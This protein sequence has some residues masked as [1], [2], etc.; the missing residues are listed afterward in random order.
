MNTKENLL[1]TDVKNRLSK[2]LVLIAMLLSVGV[3][4]QY[5]INGTGSA[6]TYTQN[7]DT[8]RGTSATLPT[9]WTNSTNSYNTSYP[10]ITSGA[11]SP[12][13]AQ[14]SGNNCYAGRANSSSTDY[15]ILQ[16][17]ATSG[18]TYLNFSAA[19]NTG[20]I[21]TG[22]T[23][24]WNVEQYNQAARATT[25][26]F[27]YRIG[28]GS[29]T[30]TDISGTTLYTA[31]T[32]SS[33]AFSVIQT[34][35]SI[36]ITGVSIPN[37]TSID[38]RFAIANGATSGSNAHIGIDDFTMYATATATCA[39]PT[40]SATTSAA[41]IT[42]STVNLTGDI[43]N[44]G[45]AALTTRAFEYST[46]SAL[47]SSSTRT[48]ASTST[49]TYTLGLTSLTPNTR[50]Y[51]RA[52]AINGCSTPQTGYSHT[53][54]YPSFTT[55]SNAPTTTAATVLTTTGFQANWTAPTGGGSESFTYEIQI[56]NNNDLSSPEVNQT[57][58]STLNYSAGPLSS[59]TIY[60]YRVR[61]LNAGGNSAW[62]NITSVTT[63][64]PAVP[65]VSPA[66]FNGTVGS[67]FSETVIAT[68]SPT[69][70]TYTGTL[71]VGLSLNA[72]NG[73][74]TG[75]PTTATISA[76]S[77]SVTAT[78]GVGPSAPATISFN[79]AKGNQTITG[80]PATQSKVYG[81]V[82]YSLSATASS[83][84]AVSY[85]SSDP[86]VAT[87]TGNTV[88]IKK[89]GTTTITASQAGDSNWN[90]ASNVTQTLSVTAKALTISG[91]SGVDK[92]YDRTTTA[93]L[94]G[95]PALVTIVSGDDVS[96][97]GTPVANFAD[98]NV[99]TKSLTVTGYT[100]SGT[101]AGNYT[102]SQ[103]TGL[104]ANITAKALTI[105]GAVVNNKT[106]DGL[107]SATIT[108]TLSGVISPDVVTLSG[109]GT[110]ASVNAANGITV[111][112]TSTIGGANAGNYTLT[113]PTGLTANITKAN[114]VITPS[115]IGVSV[116]G[117]YVLPN[118]AFT[119]NSDG[120]ITYSMTSGGFATLSGTT[121]TGVAVGSETLT[122][123]QAAS[124]NYNAATSVTVPVSVS[125][126]TYVDG[127]WK[128][129]STGNW[130]STA[131]GSTVTWARRVSGS[132]VAQT[133]PAQA[134]TSGSANKIYIY[135]DVTLAGNNTA[136]DIVI[137]I[138]PT[139][140]TRIGVLHANI[141]CTFGKLVV[142]DG[143]TFSKEAN[144]VSIDSEANGG[145]LEIKDGGT[146]LYKHT[147]A[148]S[149]AIWAAK[150][151]F[152]ANSIFKVVTVNSSAMLVIPNTTDVSTYTDP[153]TGTTACFGNVIIDCATGKMNLVPSGFNLPLTHKD[154]IFRNNSD[155]TPLSTG[156]ITTTVGGNLVVE[157]TY[158]ETINF[159]ST[160]STINITVKGNFIHNGT[161]AFR[162]TTVLGAN[163]I[164][165]IEGNLLLN[166]GGSFIM[167]GGSGS[168]TGTSTVNLKGNLTISS[169]SIINSTATGANNFNFNGIG[170][171]LTSA[172]LQAIDIAS[173]GST[174]NN[175]INF[176][177]NSGAYAK[178]INQNLALGTNSSLNVL[179][180]GSLDFGLSGA[181]AL[182]VTGPTFVANSGSILKITS[183]DGVNKTGVSAGNVQTTS[184]T[185]NNLGTYHFIGSL[186]PQSTGNAIENTGTNAFALNL[187][188]NKDN[189][190]DIV[191]LN[192]NTKTTGELNIIKGTFVETEANKIAGTTGKLTMAADGIY[193]TAVTSANTPQLSGTYSLAS[194]STIELNANANQNFNASNTITYRNLIFSNGGTKTI[195][196]TNE[197][198]LGTVTIKDNTTVDASTNTFGG[199]GTNLTM[200]DTSK[201]ILGS[202][203]DP[204]P[205][206]D[207]VY[208]L[209]SS[210]TIEFTGNSSTQ[211]RVQ[212]TATSPIPYAK[213]IVSGTNV[214]AGT[215]TST[216]LTF[217]TSGVF[218]VT[219][220][221]VYKV[222]NPA[223]FSGGTVTAVKNTNNP[224]INLE[225]G[226]TVE[227]NGT[228]DQTITV[229]TLAV[230]ATGNYQN[231]SISGSGTKSPVG[232][233]TVNNLTSVSGGI[234]KILE[235][236]ENDPANVLYAHK[237]V[238]NTT[239]SVIFEN[240]AQL[241][242][243]SDA[244]NSGNIESQRVASNINNLTA[245]M[246]YIYWSS[247]VSGQDLKS[248]SP[249]TPINRIYQ[250]NEATDFFA[251]I[252]FTTEPNFV[253]G[254][255]YAFRAE[256]TVVNGSSKVYKFVGTPNNGTVDFGINRSANSGT[257][258]HGYNLVG[259]PYPSN[260]KFS[261][262]YL[263]NSSLIWN[264]AYFWT[265]NNFTAQ[266]A[267]SN[268]TPNNYAIFNGTGGN[269]AT[270]SAVGTGVTATPNGIVK[271]GQ[272]FIV[273]KKVLG[274]GTLE[275]KN[276]YS[277]SNVLRVTDTGAFFEKNNSK[278]RFWLEM[279]APNN[280]VNTILVGYI[281]GAT[282]DFEIDYDGELF[283]VGSDSFYSVLGAKKLAIQGKSDNF[284][285][286][287]IVPLGTVYSATGTYSIKLKDPEGIFGDGQNVYLR[288]KLL[289]KYINL[290]SVE[291]YSFTGTKGTN[292]TRF[293]IVYKEDAVLGTGND[294]K[295]D[296]VVYRDGDSFVVRS[297]KTLG[298]IEI[299]DS[300]GRLVRQLSSKD[301]MVRLDV[302]DLPGAIYIIKAD[303]SGDIK[304][305]KIIK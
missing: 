56:D 19:N 92:I 175:N 165:T 94:S 289:N 119:T 135:T 294:S 288:D 241:L 136:K 239:G 182:N 58:I 99:G 68:N 284:N 177:V 39:A 157:N 124:T 110:F 305:K 7:F 207:G 261:E 48:E 111:T 273:Q 25:V 236:A 151:M 188:I 282:N 18:Q 265:N 275:F 40:V 90:A 129:T 225:T 229:G 191:N 266:Q 17:Q 302:S 227:Y 167:N 181:T 35:R 155:T 253:A 120:A 246:D 298:D 293:E 123:N 37:G 121:I 301:K 283:V 251:G 300:G 122:V 137:G 180:G 171:G 10:V 162:P 254:K 69:N 244:A 233:L 29:Y 156:N 195:G 57:G 276:S 187:I 287:D 47:A 134:P 27:D 231:L 64:T 16:K 238:Q 208:N 220:T 296:F 93:S 44:Q 237:G 67:V 278:D 107:N 222:P 281:P 224:T 52:Y 240:N 150:E 189:A 38:F 247:P 145:I 76:I 168:L 88:S 223:G 290:N 184:R 192:T 87:V 146:F 234:L 132:W 235:T 159:A 84:L 228:A 243:D 53:S 59:G 186:T 36:T 51:Y 174:R 205:R 250:Y 133:L 101:K 269:G 23:V 213:V 15:A 179:S 34:A 263:G 114:A 21:I 209:G 103:P 108:G 49:G 2:Y 5:S 198:I 252:N 30:Q 33:T 83:A 201:L 61:T 203:T 70:Y 257:V 60:Y 295:S 43:T 292:N 160:S 232:S 259:N 118:T 149:S 117:T 153:S 166:N 279:T 78:N 116:G 267:G 242:Q 193:K 71:P 77:I 97:T 11:A 164:F 169:S 45:G 28:S 291:N 210:S 204:K 127:D 140:A 62:S 96:L 20:N 280:L 130:S 144:G 72:S 8:F 89:V 104:S 75:T 148:A 4:G 230:P 226:S 82:D 196:N 260:I 32:G 113:Q 9:N 138:D 197:N 248:F 14:A 26:D 86:T 112:S 95:T 221:G 255:G 219:G 303:N 163:S 100:L 286:G 218:T 217:Q 216:G 172:T 85:L 299:Y 41:S 152:H 63:N 79:I 128:S 3:W 212:T 183:T 178:L 272:G 13:V 271:V 185:Y 81:D 55:L 42:T 6:N 143:G 22:F 199:A 125:T 106:Y 24:T 214:K 115:T 65:V 91:L 46:S 102:L 50:Y 268:Y 73:A 270:R 66:T 249:G 173:T 142:E 105:A 176:N 264:T 202:G 262:L 256:S 285:T 258:V 161:L 194:G 131:S 109:T 139:N 1:K 141:N 98:Y 215:T 31:S 80:L 211:I 147:A 200:S 54:S 190:T 245:Q 74:I 274:A 126:V 277:A 170:D 12:T 304:T 206:M 154:L 158:G 297:S